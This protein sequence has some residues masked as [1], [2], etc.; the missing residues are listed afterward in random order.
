[1]LQ[2]LGAGDLSTLLSNLLQWLSEEQPG[3]FEAFSEEVLRSKV[4]NFLSQP[5]LSPAPKEALLAYLMDEQG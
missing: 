4:E 5:E 2:A 3:V 1:M